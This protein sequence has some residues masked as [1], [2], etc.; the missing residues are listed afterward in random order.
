MKDRAGSLGDMV[1]VARPCEQH[2][3][4]CKAG[5]GGV[6]LR[7]ASLFGSAVSDPQLQAAA[8]SVDAGATRITSLGVHA[9]PPLQVVVAQHMSVFWDGIAVETP[10]DLQVDFRL[11]RAEFG[12]LADKRQVFVIELEPAS[13]VWQ[14]QDGQPAR[15]PLVQDTDARAALQR[16]A[17]LPASTWDVLG[18]RLGMSLEEAK[19]LLRSHFKESTVAELSRP[20]SHGITAMTSCEVIAAKIDLEV[21]KRIVKRMREAGS[22]GF[23]NISV[24]EQAQVAS[25]VRDAHAGALQAENCKTPERQVLAFGFGLEVIH[26]PD[27]REE[28][29]LFR[30]R[31]AGGTP[32]VGAIYRDIHSV[33]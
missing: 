2:R 8:A 28:L 31:E 33:E 9:K 17:S 1:R 18:I 15:R 4:A 26:S 16:S 24:E 29:V 10:N 21:R 20:P 5:V 11:H 23:E 7:L 30:T 6:T 12:G 14:G 27:L 25:Q 22:T 19:T 32:V 3:S 13:L